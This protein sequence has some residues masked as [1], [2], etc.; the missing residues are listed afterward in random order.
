MEKSYSLTRE[1]E[2]SDGFLMATRS[3]FPCSCHPLSWELS[4]VR[5]AGCFFPS[6]VPHTVPDSMHSVNGRRADGRMDGWLDGP[7]PSCRQLPDH[8]GQFLYF[9]LCLNSFG[10]I[11]KRQSVVDHLWI[12]SITYWFIFSTER[13]RKTLNSW[14]SWGLVL[15]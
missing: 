11:I 14:S 1:S 5:H 13:W 15:P 12:D 8:G 2:I 4:E 3:G 7:F 9:S 10:P 6:A